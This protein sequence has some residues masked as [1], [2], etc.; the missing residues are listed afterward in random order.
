M[1]K[2]I[3]PYDLSKNW[4]RDNT[5]RLMMAREWLKKREPSLFFKDPD[6]EV[7]DQ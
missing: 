3:D 5:K 1:A 4:I 7:Q 6:E 2:G